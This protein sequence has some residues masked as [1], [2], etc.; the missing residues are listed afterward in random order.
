M[1]ERYLSLFLIIFLF[2][3]FPS[4][5]QTEDLVEIYLL[6]NIDENRNYCIDIPGYKTRAKINRK[7]QAHT[8]YSYQGEVGIDQ[9]FER[10]S[11]KN[12]VFYMP[13]FKV[14]MVAN[15]IKA[16]SFLSLSECNKTYNKLFN[17]SSDNK[18]KPK[19]DKSLCITLSQNSSRK[20]K[21]GSPVHLI[22][23]LYLDKCNKN[24]KK[25]QSW[26]FR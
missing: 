22:R 20:G 11:I 8:C 18:I 1:Y 23:D 12:G 5:G 3:K 7:L 14:C 26:G 25:F 4:Y 9:G 13:A 21:G 16:G 10:K 17:L 19:I 24:L 15:K 2:L 6:D